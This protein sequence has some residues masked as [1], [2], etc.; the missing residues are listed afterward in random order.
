MV[1]IIILLRLGRLALYMPKPDK[2]DAFKRPYFRSRS[3]A[4]VQQFFQSDFGL[5]VEPEIELEEDLIP[6]YH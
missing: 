3:V 5:D 6:T 2:N 1:Y 4:K